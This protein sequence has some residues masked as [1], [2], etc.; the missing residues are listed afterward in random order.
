MLLVGSWRPAPRRRQRGSAGRRRR[1]VREEFGGFRSGVEHVPTHSCTSSE[2]SSYVTGQHII[3]DEGWQVAMTR[4]KRG[5]LLV[6]IANRESPF[7]ME[8]I[9]DQGIVRT[10]AIGEVLD[11][12]V[13]PECGRAFMVERTSKRGPFLGCRRY[14]RCKGTLQLAMKVV[15][16]YSRH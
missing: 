1:L 16:R 11:S 12:V 6:T 13:C 15:T 2:L 4:A 9:R 5:V 7:L 14:P 8:L 10:N 3:V